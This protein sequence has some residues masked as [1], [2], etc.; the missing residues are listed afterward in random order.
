MAT[1][2][3]V[4]AAKAENANLR[5]RTAAAIAKAAWAILELTPADTADRVAWA[6]T[7]IESAESIANS[8]M[9]AVCGNVTV[10]AAVF[11]P[12]DSDIEYIVGV[13]INNYAGAAAA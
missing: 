4:Y 6:K 11:N 9:W 13:L 10:Q 7:A 8:W 12:T 5:N 2:L 3:E 1:L